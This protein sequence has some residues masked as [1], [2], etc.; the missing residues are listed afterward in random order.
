MK[1]KT[2]GL[3]SLMLVITLTFSSA[4]YAAAQTPDTVTALQPESTLALYALTD[5]Y[6]NDI[7]IPLSE[8]PTHPYGTN[9][10]MQVPTASRFHNAD[11]SCKS[12]GNS[13]QCD[14][15]ARYAHDRFW[16][17]DS[18]YWGSTWTTTHADYQ[19]GFAFS[20]KTTEA[21]I[22]SVKTFFSGLH[23]G[24]FIRYN[25]SSGWQHSVFFD[26]IDSEGIWV[27]ECNQDYYY[28]SDAGLHCGVSYHK[29]TFDFILS[30]YPSV[31]YY[32]EHTLDD[33]VAYNATR[34]KVDC[35]N[36]NGYLLLEHN[37]SQQG[38][39]FGTQMVCDDCG[40]V[41]MMINSTDP[42]LKEG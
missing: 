7:S 39:N 14:G 3:L 35:E 21:K 2:R 18:S 13:N 28:D 38:S 37:F 25:T 6:A 17:K 30:R 33:P 4:G 29:Y 31:A 26:N 41:G 8:Y 1:K 34:H 9:G 22:L 42:E 27:Y 19:S 20:G 15:F 16:H 36:C 24:A 11:G 32:V 23:R 40:Y 10:T 12:Y 5:T